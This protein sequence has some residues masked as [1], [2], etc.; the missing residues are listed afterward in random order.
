MKDLN[1][2]E[3]IQALKEGKRV[4]R[5][6]WNGKGMWI[7]LFSSLTIGQDWGDNGV[8]F[9]FDEEKLGE[10]QFSHWKHYEQTPVLDGENGRIEETTHKLKDCICM[11]TAT[12]EVQLGWLA[13]Q[14]DILSEDWTILGDYGVLSETKE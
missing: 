1:F 4:A 2:G 8:Q 12:Q 7:A 11:F 5:V 13:S 6:G 14:A 10:D 9:D 3:A